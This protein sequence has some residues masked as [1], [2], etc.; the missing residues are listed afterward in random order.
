MGEPARTLHPDYDYDEGIAYRGYKRESVV[1]SEESAPFSPKVPEEIGV[2]KFTF[3]GEDLRLRAKKPVTIHISKGEE[4]WFAENKKLD[5]FATGEDSVSAIQDFASQ[6][7]HFYKRYKSLSDDE[8]LQ[9]ARQLKV[10]F[11]ENFVEEN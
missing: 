1:S 10:I 9:Y 3:V 6:V 11:A 8:L 7:I 2:P 4:L 5:I